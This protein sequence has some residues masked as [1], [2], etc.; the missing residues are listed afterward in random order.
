MH[1]TFFC[2]PHYTLLA[3]NNNHQLKGCPFKTADNVQKYLPMSP[4]TS[5]GRMKH[6]RTVIRSTRSKAPKYHCAPLGHKASIINETIPTTIPCEDGSSDGQ[7]NKFFCLASLA[8]SRTGTFYTDTTGAL[9]AISLNGKQYYFIVYDY[10]TNYIFTIPIKMSPMTPSW[11]PS[12]K[13]FR[14]SRTKAISQPLME[15]T[16]KQPNL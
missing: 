4:A 16:T 12:R 14:N 1:Q 13:Y 11:R 9:P 3:A 10:D 15:L 6:P 2:P 5:K 7:V 8:D